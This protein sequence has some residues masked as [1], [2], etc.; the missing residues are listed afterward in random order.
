LLLVALLLTL[1]GGEAIGL[2]I[3]QQVGEQHL[4]G[5]GTEVDDPL[6]AVVLGLMTFR[7]ILP[8]VTSSLHVTRA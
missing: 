3:A 4:L 8:H 1:S 2:G 5:L 6:A 7:P